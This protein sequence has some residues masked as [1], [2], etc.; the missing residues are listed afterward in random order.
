MKRDFKTSMLLLIFG[1]P[2]LFLA[3]IA[4]LYF[5]PC[6]MNNDC[7]QA[8][9]PEIIHTPVPTIIPATMVLPRIGGEPAAGGGTCTVSARGLLEAW[10]SNG[11][12]EADPFEFVDSNETTCE[13]TYTDVSRLFTEANLWYPGSP[14]CVTCH[15]PNIAISSAQMDLSSYAGILSG[16]RRASP[17]AAGNDILG[18]GVWLQAKLYEQ[19]FVLEVMPLGRPADAVAEDGPTL[20]AGR[21]K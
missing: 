9:L 6:G 16:S 3:F 11:Y 4:G 5:I 19:L 15:N 17:E 2:V 12:P 18:G 20:L 1:M 13:A 7:S 21:Q 8:T 10:V 14:A